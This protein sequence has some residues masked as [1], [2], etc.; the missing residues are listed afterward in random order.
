MEG[1]KPRLTRLM[2][3]ISEANSVVRYVFNVLRIAPSVH[4]APRGDRAV[5]GDEYRA[6]RAI[7]I[8]ER[9]LIY[10]LVL[11]GQYAAIGIVLV[12]KGFTRFKELDERKFA[13]YV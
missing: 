12:A 4:G 5:D 7:G 2:L 13:E 1:H 9:V 6:G 8:L 3:V 10:F 11:K